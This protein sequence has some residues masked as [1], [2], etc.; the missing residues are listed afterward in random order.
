MPFSAKGI[1]RNSGRALSWWPLPW[2]PAYAGMTIQEKKRHSNIR[3]SSNRLLLLA[4]STG[5]DFLEI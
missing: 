3:I 5:Y 4:I 1:G 2:M